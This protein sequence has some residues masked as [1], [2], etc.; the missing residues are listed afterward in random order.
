MDAGSTWELR[1]AFDL[2][3]CLGLNEEVPFATAAGNHRVHFQTFGSPNNPALVLIQGL[4]L[5][6]RFWFQLPE[7][8]ANDPDQPWFVIVPDNRGV[9]QSA[10]P[11]RP[12]TMADMADDV[13][14][15]L[16]AVGVQR[17]VVTGISMGGM[18]AQQVALRHPRRVAGLLLMA[19]WPGLPYGKLPPLKT[20][21][22]LID[23]AI[24][25][26]KTIDHLAHLLL[27][28]HLHANANELLR[29]WVNL[30][31]EAAPTRKTFLGQFAAIS[32]HSTGHRLERIQAPVR[33]VTGD[34]DRLVPPRTSEVLASRIRGAGLEVLPRVGHAIPLLDRQVVHR[35]VAR[36]RAAM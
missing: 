26:P 35:N 3:P 15:V 11:T 32:T 18:I 28:E 29:D 36:L 7:M 8:L 6:G 13:A 23:S 30:M 19:T 34:E 1:V 25:K 33:V 10:M 5:D 17:A 2:R 12:W 27:P 16:D 31:R 4:M 24:R 21:N 9:G 20:L 22:V 14:A